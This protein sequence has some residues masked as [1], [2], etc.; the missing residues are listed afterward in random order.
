MDMV[1]SETCGDIKMIEGSVHL[2]QLL[3]VFLW[4]CQGQQRWD[5]EQENLQVYGEV[6]FEVWR[7]SL[8]RGDA[9]VW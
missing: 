1:K 3:L 4:P 7:F 8:W 5:L 6:R 2:V 9:C